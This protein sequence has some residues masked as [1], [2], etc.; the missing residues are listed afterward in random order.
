MKGDQE[1]VYGATRW[2]VIDPGNLYDWLERRKVDLTQW[3]AGGDDSTG[4]KITRDE[5][6]VIFRSY[7]AELTDRG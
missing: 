6:E 1:K 5:W 2:E 4:E 3:G 7:V